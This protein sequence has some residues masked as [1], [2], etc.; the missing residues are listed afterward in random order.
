MTEKTCTKCGEEKPLDSFPKQAAGKLGLSS[1]CR[2][3]NIAR[4]RKWRENNRE[5]HKASVANWCAKNKVRRNQKEKERRDKVR[6][7]GGTVCTW[8]KDNPVKNA[9]KRAKYRLKKVTQTPSL[10]PE[11]KKAIED[12]Y[13]LCRD[14][15][16]VSGQKY[17]VDHIVPISK[18]G[19][20]CLDN[21]QVL[22]ADMNLS[23]GAN[24]WPVH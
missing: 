8:A 1:Q 22:P 5:R 17:H 24:V 19:P 14:L 13:W 23:K 15:E 7:E 4:S 18:G 10:S 16:L 9:A 20:H 3:C 21:L 2:A 12:L 6:A 11:E